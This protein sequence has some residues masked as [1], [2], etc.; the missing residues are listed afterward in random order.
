MPPARSKDLRELIEKMLTLDWQKRPGINDILATPIMKQRIS[1]WLSH[2]LHVRHGC[3]AV[4][5]CIGGRT[6]PRHAHLKAAHIQVALTLPACEA[7]LQ[8]GVGGGVQGGAG[9]RAV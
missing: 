5:G 3:R 1:K 7:R 6:H 4:Q 8:G 2:S 9:G